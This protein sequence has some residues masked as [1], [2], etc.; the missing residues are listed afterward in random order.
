MQTVVYLQQRRRKAN[1]ATSTGQNGKAAGTS[2][3]DLLLH[4]ELLSQDFMRL[5]L[6]EKNV[7][8]RDCGSR[9]Q[10]TE[11]YLRHIIPLPQRTLP[12][13][14]WGRRMEKSR[15]KQT[16][17]AHRSDNSSS[18]HSRK[19]PLIVYDG[20]SSHSGPLKVKKPEGSIVSIG[21]NDRLKPPPAANLSNPIRK[22]SGNTSS[23]QSSQ[24]S[25]DTKNLKLE[26]NTSGALKSPEVKNKIQRVTW[27]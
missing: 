14:R 27:P 13:T 2:D 5:V 9:D 11:L 21:S 25:S 7:S 10:L 12:N 15:G 1:M 19:R 17:V 24:R 16:P 6:N 22:L 23:S 26:E 3:A 8:T 4:P 20:S 18:D